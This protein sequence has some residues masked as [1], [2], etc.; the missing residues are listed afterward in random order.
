MHVQEQV[1]KPNASP[2]AAAWERRRPG[3]DES[4]WFIY[5]SCLWALY[6]IT[7]ALVTGKQSAQ[8]N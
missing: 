8:W 2:L 4:K 7:L 5:P 3:S 1:A 6:M